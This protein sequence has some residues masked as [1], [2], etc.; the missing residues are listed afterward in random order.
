ML[1]LTGFDEHQ[2]QLIEGWLTIK[3]SAFASDAEMNHR[4]DYSQGYAAGK[5]AGVEDLIDQVKQLIASKQSAKNT[6][7]Q[8][9][10]PNWPHA[11][12]CNCHDCSR[13]FDTYPEL[14]NKSN[15]K[16]SR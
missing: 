8:E 2:L 6:Q 1:D 11:K 4:N 10:L 15:Q 16:A 5:Q 9:R 7:E 14:R 12:N 13:L 3:C